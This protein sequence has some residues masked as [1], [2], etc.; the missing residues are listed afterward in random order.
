MVIILLTFS[1]DSPGRVRTPISCNISSE[2]AG[3]KCANRMRDLSDIVKTWDYSDTELVRE[4]LIYFWR[5]TTQAP[6]LPVLRLATS[7]QLLS[8]LS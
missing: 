3:D 6:P 8:L 5:R 7:L 2:G 1:K 4:L